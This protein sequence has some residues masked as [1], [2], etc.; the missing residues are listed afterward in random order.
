MLWERLKGYWLHPD[1]VYNGLS[2]CLDNID[3]SVQNRHST[4]EKKRI[5]SPGRGITAKKIHA[6]KWRPTAKQTNQRAKGLNL[7]LLF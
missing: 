3:N 5:I 1:S 7:Q 4:P 2:E 6:G